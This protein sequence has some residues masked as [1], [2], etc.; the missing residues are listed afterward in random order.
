MLVRQRKVAAPAAV[1]S[2]GT[3]L[4]EARVR[5]AMMVRDFVKQD[6]PKLA[7][8]HAYIRPVLGKEHPLVQFDLVRR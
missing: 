6:P 5:D 4:A 8:Q 7:P 1:S 3:D 2:V